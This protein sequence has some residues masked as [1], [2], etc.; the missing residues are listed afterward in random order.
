MAESIWRVGLLA[1]LASVTLAGCGGEDGT[2]TA[3]PSQGAP[4]AAAEPA[5]APIQTTNAAPVILGSPIASVVAGSSFSFQ[6]SATDADGDA[7]IY[8]AS[9]VPGW[10]S[11]DSQT[12]TLAGTP[13]EADVG[14]SADITIS[15]TDGEATVALPVFVITV[16]S[17]EAPS[18]P[19]ITTAPAASTPKPTTP[20]NLAP[21]I[22]GSAPTTVQATQTY[23][24][25]PSARDPEGQGLT[26]SISNK[27][28]WASFSTSTG[29]L[30]GTPA[31]SEA[32]R[33]FSN[34]VISVSDG[35]LRASLPAFSISV[36]AA[37]NRAPTV[38]GS[39]ATTATVGTAYSFRPT[40][41][42]PDGQTL[43]WSITNKPSWASFSTSSGRLSGT[44][45]AS[46]AGKT[47]ANIRI[48]ASDGSAQ[49]SLP[50]FSITVA[51]AANTAP[52]I[53]GS[54]TTSLVAGSN[55]SFT[56]TASDAQ[57]DKLSFSIS[58]RPSWASFDTTTGRL[59]G[60]AQAGTW[61]GIS[62]SV[63]DGKATATLPTFTISVSAAAQTPPAATGTAVVT[64]SAPTKNTDGTALTDL[65]GY[66][67]YRG[68]EPGVWKEQVQVVGAASTSYTFK[69]LP[70]GTHYF[71]VAAVNN[72]G[73]ESPLSA[74]GSKTVQ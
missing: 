42:D 67:V 15:V 63:S 34:I 9:G 74:V 4:D 21:T 65:Y 44:P 11:F 7:L 60:T 2:A 39:P 49:T 51:A 20:A 73:T 17:A 66:W 33:T 16:L 1:A 27:P 68:T 5:P 12:G 57:G 72:A 41:S 46:D 10:A 28:S 47:T 59:Y 22:S 45:A 48:T 30:S 31:S 26:F 32:G 23:S 18:P 56:P 54:P 29:R 37:P 52:T 55:Y 58:N 69:Q 61:S 53:S 8:A 24:F 50:T 36:T 43:T 14:T 71:A 40:G 13:S 3:N 62:I 70:A 6:A 35:S 38:A 25:T 19:P 64:W